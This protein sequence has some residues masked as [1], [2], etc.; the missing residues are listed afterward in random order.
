LA[1]NVTYE[2]ACKGTALA[3]LDEVKKVAFHG[4]KDEVKL[5]GIGKK[6]KVIQRNNVRM[7]RDCTKRLVVWGESQKYDELRRP[8]CAPG[9]P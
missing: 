8:R 1:K 2:A 5:P 4:L 7:E 9:A 3:S 6:K